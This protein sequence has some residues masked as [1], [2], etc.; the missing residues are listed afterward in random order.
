MEYCNKFCYLQVQAEYAKFDD[1]V[2]FNGLYDF[3]NTKISLKAI[4]FYD[5]NPVGT[6]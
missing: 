2:V 4:E 3:E 6:L 5:A 1:L